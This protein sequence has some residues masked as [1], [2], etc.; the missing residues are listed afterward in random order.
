MQ[1]FL[2]IDNMLILLSYPVNFAIYCS[3]S[4][5]FRETFKRVFL[6][7]L[8]PLPGVRSFS[9]RRSQYLSTVS[10]SLDSNQFVAVVSFECLPYAYV[11]TA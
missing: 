3:M 4:S 5:Q 9:L 11:M 8:P 2:L 6:Q 10:L 1:I 7:K